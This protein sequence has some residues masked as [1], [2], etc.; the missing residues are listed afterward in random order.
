MCLPVVTATVA[1]LLPVSIVI[2]IQPIGCKSVCPD[3]I[4]LFIDI[5]AKVGYV[6]NP[7]SIV[8]VGINQI[9][10]EAFEHG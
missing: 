2:A 3:P 4:H 7:T 6:Q 10:H 9:S 8:Q 1:N 5:L